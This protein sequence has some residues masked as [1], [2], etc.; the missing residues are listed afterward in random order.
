MR[1]PAYR[2]MYK[3]QECQV[4]SREKYFPYFF[5]FHITPTYIKVEAKQEKNPREWRDSKVKKREE[6]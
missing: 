2:Y 4:K 5:L 3:V 1:I 6:N